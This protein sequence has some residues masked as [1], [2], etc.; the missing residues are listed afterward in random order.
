MALGGKE[1]RE[2]LVTRREKKQNDPWKRGEQKSLTNV[3][4][5]CVHFDKEAQ[6][7][8]CAKMH[9]CTLRLTAQNQILNPTDPLPIQDLFHRFSIN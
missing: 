5:L 8:R 7:G 1:V 3:N 2:N 4:L 9:S 6:L